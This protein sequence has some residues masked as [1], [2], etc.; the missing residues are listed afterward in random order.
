[1]LRRNLGPVQFTADGAVIVSQMILELG[2]RFNA[3]PFVDKPSIHL[4]KK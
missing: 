4:G 3:I 2:H 1:M